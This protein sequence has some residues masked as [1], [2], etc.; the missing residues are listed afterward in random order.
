MNINMRTSRVYLEK[1]RRHGGSLPNDRLRIMPPQ[2]VE[3]VKLSIS[4]DRTSHICTYHCRDH[5]SSIANPPTSTLRI[6]RAHTFFGL[7]SQVLQI[8]T[9]SKKMLKQR[10]EQ[11]DQKKTNPAA[12]I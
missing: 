4:S 6:S 7:S 11:M 1:R 9:C 10:M 8:R 5:R 3:L 2:L 12:K